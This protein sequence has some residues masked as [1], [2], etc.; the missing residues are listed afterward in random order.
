[1]RRKVFGLLMCMLLIGTILPAIS[2]TQPQ[3]TEIKHFATGYIIA[4]GTLTPRDFPSIIGTSMW[5]LHFSRPYND[6]R[7]IIFYWFI[8]L[9]ETAS[10]TIYSEENGE[11]LWQHQGDTVPQLRILR[12]RGIYISEL[13]EDGLLHIELSGTIN[14]IQIIEKR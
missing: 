10:V 5:K 9:S 8:R 6:D 12:F 3:P 13:S 1:M 11:V 4:E 14:F 7:A 2:A